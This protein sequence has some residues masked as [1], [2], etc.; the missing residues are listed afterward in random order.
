MAS[1]MRCALPFALACLLVTLTTCSAQPPSSPYG[2]NLALHK[3]Y[4][5]EPPPNYGDCADAGDRTQLTDGEYTTGYFWVQPST[6]G[7]VHTQTVAIT[8]DLGQPE[9]IA[10][11]SYSTAAGVADVTW[12]SSILVLASDDGQ[13]WTVLGDLVTLSNKLGAPPPTPYQTHR[14]V[15]G[16]LHGHGRFV[17]LV[18]DQTPY[19][20]VDE[21]EVYEGRPEWLTAP[22][23]GKQ[24]TMSPLEYRRS[25]QVINSIQYRQ[26]TDLEQI[27]AE[28]EGAK[29]PEAEKGNLRTRAE[30][31]RAEVE[32]DQDVPDGF[33]TVLPLNDLHARV[34]ALRAPL[35]RGRGY[36]GVTVWGGYRYDPLQPLDTPAQPPARPPALA[37]RLMC[38]EHRAEV[39]NL[40]NP[41]DQPATVTLKVSGLGRYA[42]ALALREVIFTDTREHI[43]VASALGPTPPKPGVLTVTIPAGTCQQVW[44]DLNSTSLPAGDYKGSVTISAPG[45]AATIVPCA[46]HVANLV[47]PPEF[48]TAIGGWDETNNRG[49][50]DVTAENMLPL[51][52]KLR[53]HGVNMPWS[54]PQ[55]MPT[56]GEYDAAGN[57]SRPPDFTA[58]DEWVERWKGAT[59][60]GLFPNVGNSFAGEP[61]GTPRFNKMVGAWVTA[62]AQHAAAQG[63]Q[64]NQIDVLLVDE[65]HGDEA[66]QTIITWAKAYHAAHSGIRVWNDPTHPDPAQVSPEFYEQAEVICPNATIFQRSG[67]TYQGFF[68]TQQR[69]G[70]ELQFYS[71]SGPSKLMDP[72][73]YY[74]GQF[75]LNLKYGGQGSHYWAFGDDA[76]NSWNAYVQPRA[77]FSPLF[78]SKTDVTD[79]KQMEA[80]R[81]GAEDV[82]YFAM[83]RARV[84]DLERRG[85]KS[86]LVAEA[87]ALLVDGPD[88]AVSIMGADKQRWDVPKDRAV[89]DRVRLRAL[90]LLEKLSRL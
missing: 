86:A 10:G 62:W 13:Q 56:P 61:M 20:V 2:P 27:L 25:R 22:P 38:R 68:V 81:E 48:S 40:A 52:H 36:K 8:I 39:L 14:F 1:P 64:P 53:E 55:V 85:A 30:K 75:W 45:Q 7:W 42:E 65:P 47:M 28:L 60:W 29:L 18:V 69:A 23:Q 70:R 35:L 41:G 90:S 6:V 31:L 83:L 76:G 73:S 5:L 88:E 80:I 87:R 71:C 57:M 89:M 37:M 17:S 3:P 50:Y 58:W 78:L 11:V 67:Q 44:L 12:P 66:D 82:E 43:P 33:T 34:Y 51:I 19:T 15:T 24:V 59:H 49:G 9:P 84:T 63:I 77:P 54:N 72:A 26:R 4:T 21:V 16:E 74:R 79:A 46:I 32:A